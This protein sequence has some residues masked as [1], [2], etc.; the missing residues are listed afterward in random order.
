MLEIKEKY[1]DER[2][3][4]I[5][6]TAIDYIED[7][8]LIPQEDIIVTITNKN[9]IKRISKSTYKSQHR[10][11]VGIRGITTTDEDFVEQLISLS[12]HDDLLLPIVNLLPLEKEEKVNTM[13]RITDQDYEKNVLFSTKR[14]LIKRT[15]ISEFENI[16][17]TGKIAITLKDD[18]ELIS[19]KLTNGDS[20]VLMCSSKGKMVKFDERE[21]RIMG[22]TASGVRG[23]NLGND[24]CVGTEIS[25]PGKLLLVVTE[26]GYSKK[27]SVDEYRETKRGSK[28][29]K[30]LNITEKN[31]DIIG[32]KSTDN[33]K[34]LMIISDNGIIIRMDV[35]SISEMG[36]V[37]KGVK[38]INL[39]DD[40]K[41]ASISIV[42]KEEEEQV[43]ESSEE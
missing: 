4:T 26:K 2:R 10:G 39:K 24:L 1:G 20:K 17:Q 25:E 34:D 42:D 22:R 16:R 41:V 30:T 5:D 11:G 7:E 29:V 12:T 3:T 38:L 35:N 28:G 14:G 27:T 32:F 6:M 36:R 37:T 31:G 40:S 9:Y 18:D 33:N 13:L 23:I 8:K 43:E 19:V 21:I 15:L